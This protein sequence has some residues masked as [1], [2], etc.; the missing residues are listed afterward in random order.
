MLLLDGEQWV[1]AAA[2]GEG[3][4]SSAGRGSRRVG[5]VLAEV[6]EKK[7]TFWQSAPPSGKVETPSLAPLQT[8]VAALASSLMRT[9]PIVSALYGV[10]AVAARSLSPARVGAGYQLEATLVDPGPGTA[11]WRR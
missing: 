9:A 6:R 8:V 2:H 10:N 1:V 4:D 3:A 11:V 5:G 7:K